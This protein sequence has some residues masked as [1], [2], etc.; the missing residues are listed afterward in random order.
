MQP[1]EGVAQ[2]LNIFG[3]DHDGGGVADAGSAPEV[4]LLVARDL[5]DGG[6]HRGGQRSGLQD[7][8]S[9]EIIIRTR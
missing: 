5:V 9:A 7:L 6:H 8:V 4:K 3:G 2:K 1:L